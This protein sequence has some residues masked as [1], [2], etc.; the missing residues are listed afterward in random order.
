MSS[1]SIECRKCGLHKPT[2]EFATYNN[3][4][5]DGVRK[6][7]KACVKLEPRFPRTKAKQREYGAEKKCSECKK[8]FPISHFTLCKSTYNGRH[9]RNSICRE[10][11]ARRRRTR[12]ATEEGRNKIRD[13]AMKA[14]YGI[15]LEE[16]HRKN[17]EQKGLCAICCK[18]ERAVRK[19]KRLMLAVD[20][21]HVTSRVRGLLCNR[22]NKG[23]G[24]FL[25]ARSN[26][27]AAID[28][29]VKYAD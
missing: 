4:K 8:T 17:A 12:Y 3:G 20:H 13:G 2:T 6:T 26:L 14:A 9:Y 16:Y 5:A 27:Q 15:N 7:C 28:Y 22:C 19:G 11:M 23:L 24:C 1:N 29:L 21:S 10:C 18:P 25:D